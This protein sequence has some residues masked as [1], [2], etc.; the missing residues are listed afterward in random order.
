MKIAL[1]TAW[2]VMTTPVLAIATEVWNLDTPTGNLG[3]THTYIST[4]SGDALEA[5][6]FSANGTAGDLFGRADGAIEVGGVGIARSSATEPD[7]IIPGEFVQLSLPSTVSRVGV[8][9]GAGSASGTEMWKLA[10]SS[11]AGQFGSEIAHGST[12]FPTTVSVDVPAGDFLDV[13][14]VSGGILAREINAGPATPIPEPRSLAAFAVG[15]AGIG[16]ILMLR[17]RRT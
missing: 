17:H 15:L 5:A 11:V 4:P 8:S 10:V 13:G 2:L 16:T 12:Q 9:F 14:A 7:E 3:L 1:A 6:G